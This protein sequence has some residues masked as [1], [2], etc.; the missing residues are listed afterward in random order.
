MD[1]PQIQLLRNNYEDAF[2][3]KAQNFAHKRKALS[4]P[5]YEIARI[6]NKSL[7]TIQQFENG[8]CFDAFLLY[9]YGQIFQNVSTRE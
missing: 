5:Q 8:R 3:R 6:T 4:I 2:K 7:R 9:A 1:S